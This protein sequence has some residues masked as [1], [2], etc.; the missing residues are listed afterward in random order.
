MPN[1]CEN[2]LHIDGPQEQIDALLEFIGFT[3]E[4]PAFDF[5]RI[6]PYPEPWASMDTEHNA[7]EEAGRAAAPYPSHDDPEFSA[8]Q[9][10]AIRLWR[11]VTTP[12][13]DAYKAKW[14]T[15]KDGYNSGGY[16]WC[17]RVW[18]TKWGAFEAER[19]DYRG[20]A[21]LTFRTAWS[22]PADEIF[23]ALHRQFPALTLTLEW[24]E[25]GMA[26]CGGGEWPSEGDWYEDT[27]WQAGTKIDEWQAKDYRGTRGG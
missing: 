16:E 18:G 5:K 14:G 27:P 21:I 8:K 13:M 6:I 24:F 19:R 20:K 12:L 2:D 3:G 9:A 26:A 25:R 23:A 4:E 17:C 11:E 7:I 22:P 15:D 1:Y 10:E